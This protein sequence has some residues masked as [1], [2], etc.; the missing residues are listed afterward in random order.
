MALTTF[1]VIGRTYRHANR[2]RQILGVLFKYGFDDLLLSLELERYLDIGMKAIFVDRGKREQEKLTRPQKL[3]RALEELGP[4]FIKFGQIVSTQSSILPAEFTAELEHLQSNVPAV[5][6]AAIRTLVEE[7][8]GKEIGAVFETFDDKPLGAASIGQ[9]HR[10]RLR[11]GED[12][13]V[14]AQRPGVRSVVEVDLEILAHLASLAERH[15]EDWRPHEPTRVV[16]NFARTLLRELDFTNEAQNIERF[17]AN[18]AHEPN[19]HV[20]RVY[21]A[22]STSRVLVMEYIQGVRPR[23]AEVLACEGCDPSLVARRGL[24]LILAQIFHHGFLHADPHPGNLFVLP[25]NRLCYIDFGMMG[26]LSRREREAFADL[27]LSI[28]SQN[29]RAAAQAFIRVTEWDDEPDRDDLEKA[30]SHFMA[31]HFN[32]PLGDIQL[33]RLLEELIDLISAFRMRL[34]TEYH[35]VIKSLAT[36]EGVG[37]M[38]DPDFDPIGEAAPFLRRFQRRRRDPRR[39]AQDTLETANDIVQLLRDLPHETRELLRQ[40]RRGKVK[41]EFEHSGLD[42][43]I[44]TIDRTVNRLSISLLAGSLVI[45]SSIMVL[46]KVPPLWGEIPILGLV[47]FLAAAILGFFELLSL[48]QERRRR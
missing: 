34:G 43:L 4:T 31:A 27:V 41:L 48:I 9:V 23:S 17:A 20:P 25:G 3:R 21:R 39:L 1:G 14:K 45:A 38:L 11:T 7:E 2:Y 10:A 40:L 24:Q 13:V 33:G 22:H 8:L 35:L 26:E 29:E 37:R 32:R 44:T 19:L 28:A 36:V 6:S 46:S 42:P 12:V 15:L 47:G 16:D 30:L 18:F 5:P